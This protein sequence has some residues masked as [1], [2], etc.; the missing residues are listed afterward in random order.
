MSEILPLISV[1]IP[2]YNHEKYVIE[3]LESIKYQTYKNIEI[4][5]CDDGSSDGSLEV[6][7]GWARANDQIRIKVLSQK[8]QGVCKTLNRLV[9]ESS[10]ELVALCASDDMLLPRSIED[11]FSFLQRNPEVGAV[12][13]DAILI[14]E[15]SEEVSASAMKSLYRANFDR[16]QWN[17]GKELIFNWSVVGPT[18]LIYRNMYSL[19][20]MY[21]EDLKVEDRDFYLRCIAKIKIGFYPSAV[22]LYRIHTDNASRK[23][24]EAKVS[25]WKQVALSN[26]KNSNLFSGVEYFF[27]ISHRVDL[28][29]SDLSVG[30]VGA[31]VLF[32]FRVLRKIFFKVVTAFF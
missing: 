32:S 4:V 27:L 11:R 25:V 23:S 21:D 9:N 24:F 17:T 28:F 14:N 6:V 13:G 31:R 8:N 5:I 15:C 30:F 3:C 22:A 18:L 7:Y 1:L 20:G 10:G 26:V 12:V 29:L 16:L 19:V 2:L